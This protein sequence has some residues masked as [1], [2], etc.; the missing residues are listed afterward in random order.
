MLGGEKRGNGQRMRNLFLLES[1][2]AVEQ[3]APR[4]CENL[5]SF[6]IQLDKTLSNLV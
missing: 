6:K 4:S 1:S 2:K 3:V 5:V